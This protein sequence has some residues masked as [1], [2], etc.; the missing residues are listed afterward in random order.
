MKQKKRLLL[1]YVLLLVMTIAAIYVTGNAMRKQRP[2]SRDYAEIEKEGT[3]RIITEYSPHGYYIS[4]DTIEGFQYELCRAIADVSGL[5]VEIRLET[6]L[7]ES[8]RLLDDQRY[9]VLAQNIPV[10]SEFKAKYLFTTPVVMSKQVL[11]QRTPEAN[12][13]K[14][15]LRNQLDLAGK[16]LYMPEGS[17]VVLRIRHLEREM[18]DTVHIVT[19]ALYSSEQLAIRVAKGEID[20]AVCDRQIALE[21]KTELPE[22]DVD[23]DIGFTQLQAW[24]VRKDAPA[25]RDSLDVWFERIRENGLFNKI[26]KRYYTAKNF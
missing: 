26:Y 5:E 16:T 19:D 25:L 7:A 20:Y 22:I 14:E 9:D 3:L 18:G 17:P 23:T 21:L 4:G 6:S 15:P 2:A 8:F 11:V 24:A 10:T 1:V 13:G 12:N